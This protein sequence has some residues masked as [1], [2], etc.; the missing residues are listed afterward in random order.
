MQQYG[1][2]PNGAIVTCL[3]LWATKVGEVVDVVERRARK[4]GNQEEQEQDDDDDDDDDTPPPRY[5]LLDTPGQ[6]EVFTWSASGEII[7]QAFSSAFP[8]PLI[9]YVMDAQQ[10]AKS[11]VSLMSGLMNVVGVMVRMGVEVV[12]ALNKCDLLPKDAPED[13]DASDFDFT[14]SKPLTPGALMRLC[15][16]ADSLQTLLDHRMSTGEEDLGYMS[17]LI[18]SMSN[19]L[20]ELY[21]NVRFVP[22]SA[23]SGQ[24]IGE[25]VR[26]VD[27]VLG[28]ERKK[29]RHESTERQQAEMQ[30]LL[31]D[32][33]LEEGGGGAGNGSVGDV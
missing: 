28:G 8:P 15:R 22:V 9:V 11:L 23:E 1:L 10:S 17:S 30:K 12:V 13:K 32:L 33:A 19:V 31:T 29:L 18:L 5:I 14:S 4:A 21:E 27:E 16:D 6:I 20:E 25:L 3:N 7:T 26:V 2:G 24:G